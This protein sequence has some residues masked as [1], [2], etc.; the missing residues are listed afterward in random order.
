VIQTSRRYVQRARDREHGRRNKLMH[1]PKYIAYMYAIV[2]RNKARRAQKQEQT[3][4]QN[5]CSPSG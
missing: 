3:D 2:K 1:K 5:Y 4:V